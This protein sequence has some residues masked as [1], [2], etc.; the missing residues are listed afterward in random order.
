LVKSQLRHFL[1]AT[2]LTFQQSINELFLYWRVNGRLPREI[3]P[4]NVLLGLERFDAVFG[5]STGSFTR[6]PDYQERTRLLGPNVGDRQ[7]V[8]GPRRVLQH[9]SSSMAINFH[10]KGFFFER[11]CID[12]DPADYDR[13]LEQRTS[14]ATNRW[15]SHNYSMLYHDY[16]STST[17]IRA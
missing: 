9:D 5:L 16:S 8:A 17:R 6:D 15:E 7:S 1:E 11:G 3:D 12:S 14:S 2:S 10:S 13:D 4:P